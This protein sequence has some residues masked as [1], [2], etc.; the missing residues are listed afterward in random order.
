MKNK[1]KLALLMF[2]LIFLL[3]GCSS[4]NKNNGKTIKDKTDSELSYVEDTI[5]TI[6]NKYAK[7]EYMKDGRIEWDNIKNDSKKIN[8]ALDTILLDLSELDIP[9]DDLIS[10][11]NELNN[12]IILIS[13][14]DDILAIDKL[15][16]LYSLIPKYMARYSDDKNKISKKEL[17]SNILA[18]YNFSNAKKWAEAKAT[19]QT[20]EDKY[21]TMMN[22]V[23][24][25]RENTYNL[26][27]VYV[28]IEELKNAINMENMELIKMKYVNLIE[29]IN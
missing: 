2:C 13:K 27:K 10:F 26:N 25:M 3:T 18:S 14:E 20:V 5:F 12:L 23:D 15:N 7:D 1:F 8:N 19:I 28:L 16:H 24:Y 17:K 22:D 29:E 4:T 21:K 6:I 9:N 11:S